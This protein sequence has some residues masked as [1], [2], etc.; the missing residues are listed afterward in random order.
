ME[1]F[2]VFV[3]T[4]FFRNAKCPIML[5]RVARIRPVTVGVGGI[6][7][8][9]WNL[10]VV[11]ALRPMPSKPEEEVEV[12]PIAPELAVGDRLE[13]DRLLLRDR[14]P[15]ASILDLRERRSGE[16]AAPRFRPCL[17][18]LGRAEQAADV[19]GAERGLCLMASPR[20]SSTPGL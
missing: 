18:Q 3:A 5:G 8:T 1:N 19:V 10:S 9:P 13:A 14:L 11:E 17:A 4:D 20:G 15:D 16:L 12:P 6:S 7:S 2:A